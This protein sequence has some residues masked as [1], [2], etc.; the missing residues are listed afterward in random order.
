MISRNI[1]HRQNVASSALRSSSF[2]SKIQKW[3]R[4]TVEY[5]RQG[6]AIPGQKCKT[7]EAGQDSFS[8]SF[9]RERLFRFRMKL[10]INFFSFLCLFFLLFDAFNVYQLCSDDTHIPVGQV[11]SEG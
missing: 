9:G 4:S 8:A 1:L 2:A 3:R 11:T 5:V 7:E 10:G 6:A